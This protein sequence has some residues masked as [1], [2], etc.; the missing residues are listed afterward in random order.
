MIEALRKVEPFAKL[1][2][3]LIP[4]SLLEIPHVRWTHSKRQKQMRNASSEVVRCCSCDMTI[5]VPT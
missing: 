5:S 1:L 3:A 2:S 4:A